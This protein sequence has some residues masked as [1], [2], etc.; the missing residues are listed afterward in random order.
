VVVRVCFADGGDHLCSASDDRTIKVWRRRGRP[1]Q[2]ERSPGMAGGEPGQDE[3][4][5]PCYQLHR[6]FAGPCRVWDCAILRPS[7]PGVAGSGGGDLAPPAVDGGGGSMFSFGEDGVCRVYHLRG[8]RMATE[9]P[10]LAENYL[11]F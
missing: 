8:I 5:E 10:G 3:Q 7:H 6:S 2:R 11:R 1:P 9:N 4:E